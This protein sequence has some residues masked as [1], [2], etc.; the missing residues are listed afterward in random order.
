METVENI[1]KSEAK[2][3]MVKNGEEWIFLSKINKKSFRMSKYLFLAKMYH[4]IDEDKELD[5]D[6]DTLE[7]NGYLIKTLTV[8]ITGEN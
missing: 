3:L 1:L 5:D 7:R 6:K 2:V 8:K 4:D